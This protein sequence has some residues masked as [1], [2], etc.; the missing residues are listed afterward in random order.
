MRPTSLLFVLLLAAFTDAVK[1]FRAG[2]TKVP[3]TGKAAKE[4]DFGKLVDGE[5][6]PGHNG[7]LS[8]NIDPALLPGKPTRNIYSIDSSPIMAGGFGFLADGSDVGGT[9]GKGHRTILITKSFTPPAL[10]AAL[11]ALHWE[12][13]PDTPKPFK[14]PTPVAAPEPA[15]PVVVAPKPMALI[16][17]APNAAAPNPASPKPV[18]AKPDVVNPVVAKPVAP[19]PEPIVKASPKAA[20]KHK[21]LHF[22]VICSR[23]STGSAYAA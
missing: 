8:T 2:Q 1:V 4:K 21:G 22:R 6:Q 5:F 12:K 23:R 9:T 7:G 13:E 14:A 15:A 20:A 11:N 17:V 18:A 3:V 10:L 19:K 16:V